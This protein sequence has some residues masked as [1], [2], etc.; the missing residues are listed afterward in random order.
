MLNRKWR[1]LLCA[2]SFFCSPR[3]NLSPL[4]WANVEQ[5]QKRWKVPHSQ[6]RRVPAQVQQNT[7]WR[8]KETVYRNSAGEGSSCLTSEHRQWF[9]HQIEGKK[10]EWSGAD[11]PTPYIDLCVFSHITKWTSVTPPPAVFRAVLASWAAGWC[12]RAIIPSFSWL[13]PLN[14]LVCCGIKSVPLKWG[15][16]VSGGSER[17]RG[18]FWSESE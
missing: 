15:Y 16:E 14:T 5:T 12:G 18:L 1:F 11:T 9:A 8:V 7:A 6:K 4:V 2:A 3:W 17:Q 10:K 13:P